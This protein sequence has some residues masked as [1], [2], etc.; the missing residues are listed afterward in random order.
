[1]HDDDIAADRLAD[2]FLKCDRGALH[3]EW[4]ERNHDSGADK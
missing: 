1:M 3:A 4:Q 2:Y